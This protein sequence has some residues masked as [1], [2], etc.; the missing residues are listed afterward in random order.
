LILNEWWTSQKDILNGSGEFSVPVF[1]G[2]CKVAVD[3]KRKEV[4]LRNTDGKVIV[5][6][7]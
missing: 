1:Y 7:R 4:E 3:G 6:L 2:K 5:D